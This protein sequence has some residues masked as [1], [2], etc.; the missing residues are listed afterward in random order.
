MILA[1]LAY[2]RGEYRIRWRLSG[3]ANTNTISGYRIVIVRCLRLAPTRIVRARILLAAF[4][5]I[6]EELH[7]LW[8]RFLGDARDVPLPLPYG[9]ISRCS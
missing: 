5:H 3:D 2:V 1:A 9:I 4:A 7:A 8:T 6:T